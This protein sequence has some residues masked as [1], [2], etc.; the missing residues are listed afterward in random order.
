MDYWTNSKSLGKKGKL[1][2][3]LDFIIEKD[4]IVY[5]VDIK[6]WIKYEYETRREVISKVR[7]AL[8]L[9]IFPFIIAR[10]VDKD[11]IYTEIIK[12]GGICYYFKTLLFPISF[13]G[14]AKEANEVLGYPTL[15]ADFLPNHKIEWIKKLHKDFAG[16]KG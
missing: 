12:K 4:K 3:N 13:S 15:A 9:G 8:K 11:T 2:P 1:P 7:I 6:N 16:R 14:L 10:Y 5:G